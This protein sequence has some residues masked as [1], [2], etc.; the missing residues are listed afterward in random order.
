M[1]SKTSTAPAPLTDEVILRNQKLQHDLQVFLLPQISNFLGALPADRGLWNSFGVFRDMSCQYEKLCDLYNSSQ[2]VTKRLYR[3]SD[4]TTL[5]IDPTLTNGSQSNTET[6][7]LPMM[8]AATQTTD[9]VQIHSKSVVGDAAIETPEPAA[10]AFLQSTSASVSGPKPSPDA[11]QKPATSDSRSWDEPLSKKPEIGKDAYRSNAIDGK[12]PTSLSVASGIAGNTFSGSDLIED[13]LDENSCANSG[14][15]IFIANDH[16]NTSNLTELFRKIPS[17]IDY[18]ATPISATQESVSRSDPVSTP[19]SEASD[20]GSAQREE[21]FEDSQRAQPSLSQ[22]KCVELDMTDPEHDAAIPSAEASTLNS[23]SDPFSF[24]EFFLLLNEISNSQVRLP[25]VV[26]E[27]AD[28]S[29]A[30]PPGEM[31]DSVYGSDNDNDDDDTDSLWLKSSPPSSRQSSIATLVTSSPVSAPQEIKDTSKP[32]DQIMEEPDEAESVFPPVHDAPEFCLAT[33]SSQLPGLTAHLEQVNSEIYPNSMEI[34]EWAPNTQLEIDQDK[35]PS[36][37]IHPTEG[38]VSPEV[39][40]TDADPYVNHDGMDT[41]TGSA[42]ISTSASLSQSPELDH[43]IDRNTAEANEN[44]QS[45]GAQQHI[46]AEPISSDFKAASRVENHRSSQHIST[47]PAAVVSTNTTHP[48]PAASSSL[49]RHASPSFGEDAPNK[50][51]KITHY[52]SKDTV[53]P[54]IASIPQKNTPNNHSNLARHIS[55]PDT[56][57]PSPSNVH[58]ASPGHAPDIPNNG[59]N[60]VH[61]S[62]EGAITLNIASQPSTNGLNDHNN[63]AA[64]NPS[65]NTPDQSSNTSG[66]KAESVDAPNKRTK[67]V[68]PSREDHI[69]LSIAP[70]PNGDGLNEQ[71]DTATPVPSLETPDPSSNVTNPNAQGVDAAQST[72]Q[73]NLAVAGN[74][75]APAAPT[76]STGTTSQSS[77]VAGSGAKNDSASTGK[78]QPRSAGGASTSG[79]KSPAYAE[80]NP[81]IRA[82][83]FVFGG[84]PESLLGADSDL[85]ELCKM[86]PAYSIAEPSVCF[87]PDAQ[88]PTSLSADDGPTEF[89]V[90]AGL[91]GKSP[92][93]LLTTLGMLY[94]KGYRPFQAYYR[95]VEGKKITPSEAEKDCVHTILGRKEW[96]VDLEKVD[97]SYAKKFV[98]KGTVRPH[99]W[100]E[101]PEGF[102]RDVCQDV[103]RLCENGFLFFLEAQLIINMSDE[104][105]RSWRPA[106]IRDK[107]LKKAFWTTRFAQRD[108]PLWTQAVN[109]ICEQDCEIVSEVERIHCL[110][111]RLFRK[112]WLEMKGT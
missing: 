99:S 4:I 68:H 85:V 75:S 43:A 3:H 8:D 1:A 105:T 14:S 46:Q 36:E 103:F 9:S 93:F 7:A 107:L 97:R 47:S 66:R 50:R 10:V 87:P 62:P 23:Q 100:D 17:A 102:E 24:Q 89:G 30:T 54:S 70:Q 104:E 71:N 77:S 111:P 64:P 65:P 82:D 67:I 39:E 72:M 88:L 20:I 79:S 32:H 94:Q 112:V 33:S 57:S 48:T 90:L 92:S 56:P 91:C 51:A 12:S 38:V 42:S 25:R 69:A 13:N 108:S 81:S 95:A 96:V 60:L 21:T 98:E 63:Q 84:K 80:I 22:D 44:L 18:S 101:V 45:T 26:W 53:A 2:D 5:S 52:N 31:S 16:P 74:H 109:C 29:D 11:L 28:S 27:E 73:P 15:A 41:E 106:E 37:Q 76:P 83:N 35:P 40:L 58:Q 34:V 78:Q 19:S 110:V 49:N 86:G 61:S 6:N 59:D 55:L